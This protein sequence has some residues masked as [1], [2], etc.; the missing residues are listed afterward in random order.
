MFRALLTASM[1]VV[2]V[3]NAHAYETCVQVSTAGTV[4]GTH[5]TGWV[6][7][8]AVAPTTYHHTRVTEWPEAEV[9]VEYYV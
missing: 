9:L 6:C 2:A 1:L 8:P 3:P 5:S 7:G 4:V